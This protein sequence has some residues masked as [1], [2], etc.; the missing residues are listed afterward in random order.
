MRKRIALG[1]VLAL[2]L[3]AQAMAAEGLSYTHLE[4]AYNRGEI[5]LEDTGGSNVEIDL[6][7]FSVSG[8]AALSDRF[9]AFAS[10]TS[11]KLDGS[12]KH[13]PLSAGLGLHWG[14]SPSIDLVTGL[15]FERIKYSSSLVSMG[16]NGYGISAGLRGALGERAEL[17]G[18]I[19][20]IDHGD[21]GSD[22]VFTVGGRF[23]FTDMFAAGLDFSWR[24][25]LPQD[26]WSLSLRY[27]FGR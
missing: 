16:E 17:S 12:V 20:H 13:K 24:D 8:S 25:K 6:D 3:G 9:F 26:I 7:G 5:N 2:G 21:F 14:L 19:K 4:V 18:Q 1:S 22:R 23:H 15:S 27:S 10:F 11:L